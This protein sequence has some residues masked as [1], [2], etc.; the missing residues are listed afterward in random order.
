MEIGSSPI[1]IST[2]DEQLAIYQQQN[3][4]LNEILKLLSSKPTNIQNIIDNQNLQGDN[5]MTGEQKGNF[6]IGHMSGGTISGNAKVA[7]VIN[8]AAQQDLAQAAAEIQQLLDQLSQTYPTK[9]RSKKMAVGAKITEE[10][11]NNPTRWQKVI[12]IIKAMGIEA[13]AEA[14]DNPIFNIAKARIEAALE[15]ES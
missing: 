8:E 15:S 14:V 4:N 11:E 9:T 12:N 5:N 13:V 6:G 2:K 3:T 7:G 1:L 10:I